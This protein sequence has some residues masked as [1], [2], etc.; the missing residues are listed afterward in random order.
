MKVL[1]IYSWNDMTS[2]ER[3]K[4]LLESPLTNDFEL[5]QFF[6]LSFPGED[7]KQERFEKRLCLTLKKLKPDFVLV[8]AGI[9]MHKYPLMIIR[10]LQKV[11]KKYPNI[12][13]GIEEDA[14]LLPY[15]SN[16]ATEDESNELF[17]IKDILF[18]KVFI[19]HR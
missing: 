1:L 10:S 15:Y 8:Q 9:A 12:R 4:I 3:F 17:E 2:L 11:K 13:F 14:A 16:S 18:R 7:F 5:S 19:N 6:I